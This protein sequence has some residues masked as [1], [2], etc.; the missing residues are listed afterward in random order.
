MQTKPQKDVKLNA[1]QN[2]CLEFLNSS[3]FA[4]Q[5]LRF[6]PKMNAYQNNIIEKNAMYVIKPYTNNTHATFQSNTFIFS[7]IIFIAMAENPG[8]PDDVTSFKRNF[9]HS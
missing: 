2:G 9:W 8:K 3:V 7:F 6:F 4:Y 5:N 1:P